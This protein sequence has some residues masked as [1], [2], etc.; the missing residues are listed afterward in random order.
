MEMREA[1][2]VDM[3][4]HTHHRKRAIHHGR[5]IHPVGAPLSPPPSGGV[6]NFADSHPSTRPSWFK[7]LPLKYAYIRTTHMRQRATV[8]P[9]PFTVH[10]STTAITTIFTR[11]QILSRVCPNIHPHT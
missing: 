11:V 6:R 5:P 2:R 10:S 9:T 3:M 8:S 7:R 1:E 4:F